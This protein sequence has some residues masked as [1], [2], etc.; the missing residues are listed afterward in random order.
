MLVTRWRLRHIP[1]WAVEP[2]MRHLSRGQQRDKLR[3]YGIGQL[4]SG[5]PQGTLD[6][7]RAARPA[8]QAW[9]EVFPKERKADVFVFDVCHIFGI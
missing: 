3:P 4:E 9:G 8:R 1:L 5:Q 2:L 6:E 7:R